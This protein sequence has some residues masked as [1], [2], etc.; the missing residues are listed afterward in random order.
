VAHRRCAFGDQLG[1]RIDTRDV[2][3]FLEPEAEEVLGAE[4]AEQRGQQLSRWPLLPDGLAA[5]GLALFLLCRGGGY[6]PPP[7][8]G[9]MPSCCIMPSVSQPLHS[10]TAL[11]AL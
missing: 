6:P 8:G 1:D 2:E 10:S 11:P 7:I 9:M 3:P 4:R 5:T